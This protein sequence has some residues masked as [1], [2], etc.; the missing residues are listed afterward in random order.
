[1]KVTMH[2]FPSKT[3][4]RL[5]ETKEHK[6]MLTLFCLWLWKPKEKILFTKRNVPQ[7]EFKDL[8]S[9]SALK[10]HT[11]SRAH[12]HTEN[13]AAKAVLTRE[14][15]K[16]GESTT[17]RWKLCLWPNDLG[18]GTSCPSLF[19]DNTKAHNSTLLLGMPWFRT[20]SAGS[21]INWLV[22]Y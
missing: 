11:R 6:D 5:C 18:S 12:T 20:G 4:A 14:K 10:T 16:S 13:S 19:F 9:V 7:F 2:M 3:P 8:L 1:M 15:V 21:E 17:T 22:R